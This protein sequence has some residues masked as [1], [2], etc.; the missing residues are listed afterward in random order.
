MIEM[1]SKEIDIDL[2]YLWVNGNDPVW[3]ARHNAAVGKTEEESA[4]NCE[5]RY[6]D[7][8]ELKFSLRS[9]EE[10]APWIRNIYI[11]TDNQ[12]PEWLNIL[13]PKIHIVDHKDILPPEAMPCFN[14]RIIEHHLFKIQGLAEHFIYA[15]DDMLIGQPVDKSFFFSEKDGYPYIRFNRRYFRKWQW[16]WDTA[17]LKKKLSNYNNAIFNT[18]LAVEKRYGKFYGGKT[19]HNIDAYCKSDY[20]KAYKEFY[21]YIRPTLVN[22]V[23]SENDMQRNLY[24]YY[25]LAN[26]RGHLQYVNQHTSFRF[27]IE[28]RKHYIKIDRYNPVLFCMNDSEYAKDEDR[29][30]ARKYLE[31][32]FPNKSQFEK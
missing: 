9:I 19:H 8:D 13:H 1:K 27:H 16:L 3:R 30:M 24:S 6:A 4:T 11:V 21:D 17:V 29:I 28:N 15:N 20:E 23:R 5:G 31:H 25:P 2:V 26:K 10:N 7:N 14:S 32:R 22:H 12:V 18:A